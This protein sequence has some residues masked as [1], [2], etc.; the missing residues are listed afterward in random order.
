MKKALI[1]SILS[2]FIIFSFSYA[3]GEKGLLFGINMASL[4]GSDVSENTDIRT[5]FAIG[6]YSTMP[7]N[8]LLSIRPEIFFS[9]KGSSR[10]SNYDKNGFKGVYESIF[11]L[12][13]IEVPVLAVVN[14]VS[15]IEFFGGVYV[16][17]FLNGETES[18]WSTEYNGEK[19]SGSNTGKIKS[20]EI[21]SLDYGV[22]AGTAIRLGIFRI[23]AR[24]SM[25]IAT[26]YKEDEADVKNSVIQI[27]GGILF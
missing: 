21:E 25:G 8:N 16:A 14:S 23:G 3:Q 15:F 17:Y 11:K 19:E 13:Y 9:M 12:N 20:N 2:V 18:K 22:V 27:L 24:Y 10:I 6:F 5:T 26:L 7:I 1:I 4:H